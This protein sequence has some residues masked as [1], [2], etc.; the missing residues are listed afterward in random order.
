MFQITPQPEIPRIKIRRSWRPV[1]WK[2]KAD[3][4][5]N[6]EMH[7]EKALNRILNVWRSSVLH[8]NCATYTCKLF[9][10]WN[11]MVAKKIFIAYT[12]EE[13]RD[14]SLKKEWPDDTRTAQLH[15]ENEEV[16]VDV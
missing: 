15:F 14:K 8:E 7:A 2:M 10:C 13:T 16:L 4:S 5:I 12:I 11:D 3:N 9:K 1:C 6:S